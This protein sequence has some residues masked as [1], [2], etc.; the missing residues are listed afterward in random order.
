[1]FNID[2][3]F[4]RNG[5]HFE[6]GSQFESYISDYKTETFLMPNE[7]FVDS[8]ISLLQEIVLCTSLK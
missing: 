3:H 6:F 5:R 1:M 7:Y 4:P 8:F 2:I